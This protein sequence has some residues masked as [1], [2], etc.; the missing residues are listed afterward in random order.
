MAR[1][2]NVCPVSMAWNTFRNALR[3]VVAGGIV[4]DSEDS[5]RLGDALIGLLEAVEEV[6][7]PNGRLA[8]TD[9]AAEAFERSG[10]SRD[11]GAGALR[12]RQYAEMRSDDPPAY[13]AHRVLHEIDGTPEY[14]RALATE[15]AAGSTPAE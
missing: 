9:D 7:A 11:L 14:A 6:Y 13:I 10:L 4:V 2:L 12:Y 15:R 8:F 1:I 3:P 5:A